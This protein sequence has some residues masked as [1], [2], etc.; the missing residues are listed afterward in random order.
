M[1][2]EMFEWVVHT[3]SPM[4]LRVAFL[5]LK[6]S[7]DAEDIT[8]EILIKYWKKNP[9][10]DNEAARKAWLYKSVIN[11]CKDELKSF[12]RSKRIA[13]QEDISYL[14]QEGSELLECLMKLDRKYLIPLHLHYYEGY[15]LK[16]IAEILHM[17]PAT[18]GSRLHRG[19]E[20]LKSML[21][22]TWNEAL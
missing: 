5:Y 15:T 8:Q 22:G 7:T 17:R 9:K 14:P 1:D 3:Y 10:F 20:K 19:K 13:L 2:V 4:L 11:R 18:V 21:G 12:W 16:E 6:S